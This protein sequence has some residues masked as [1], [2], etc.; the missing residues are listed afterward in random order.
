MQ[1]VYV[2]DIS[3]ADVVVQKVVYAYVRCFKGNENQTLV[4]TTSRP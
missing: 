4:R 2:E 3:L 1:R